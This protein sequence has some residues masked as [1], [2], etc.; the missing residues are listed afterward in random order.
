MARP[1]SR[2]LRESAKKFKA[3]ASDW[4]KDNRRRETK[5]PNALVA[6][7]EVFCL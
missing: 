4:A 7:R 2:Y 1:Q 5:D 3:M 6:L